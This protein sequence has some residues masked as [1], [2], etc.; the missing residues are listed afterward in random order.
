MRVYNQILDIVPDISIGSFT[1]NPAQLQHMIGYAVQIVFTGSPGGTVKLQASNDS[2]SVEG[3]PT[4]WSDVPNSS[5]AISASGV[6]LINVTDA[7]YNWVRV[8]YTNSAGSP[9]GTCT[10][11]VNAKGV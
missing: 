11:T 8:V 3:F 6:T 2:P 7:Y 4:N 5:L 1:S 9:T 10:I